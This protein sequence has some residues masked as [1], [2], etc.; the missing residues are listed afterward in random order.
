MKN[1]N[2]KKFTQGYNVAMTTYFSAF[3]KFKGHGLLSNNLK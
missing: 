3:A 1:Y 2:M